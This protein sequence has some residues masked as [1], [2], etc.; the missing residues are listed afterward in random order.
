MSNL[1]SRS[2]EEYIIAGF[3]ESFYLAGELM[4]FILQLILMI[5]HYVIFIPGKPKLLWTAANQVGIFIHAGAVQPNRSV[6]TIRFC[7][8]VKT[9]EDM[10]SKD[11][12]L[13]K[14]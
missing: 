7:R 12:I 11:L 14:Y 2:A 8:T 5:N 10:V 9:A 3:R 4:L 6:S 13:E 1:L